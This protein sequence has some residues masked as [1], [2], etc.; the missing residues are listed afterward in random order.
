MGGQ[1]RVG[2]PPAHHAG[3]DPAHLVYRVHV[4]R[5]VPAREFIDISLEVFPAHLVEHSLVAPLN[6]RPEGFDAVGM[7]PLPDVLADPV[8][9]RLVG[10]AALL[11]KPDIG[12][13][14]VRVDGGPVSG[15]PF[16]EALQRLRFRVSNSR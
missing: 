2:Q 16:R 7:G 11:L 9:N 8:T 12:R 15:M 10:A 6:G 1:L 3:G 13:V 4:P 14:L 5:V